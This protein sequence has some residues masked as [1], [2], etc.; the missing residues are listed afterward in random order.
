MHGVTL[1]LSQKITKKDK[2]LGLLKSSVLFEHRLMNF[3]IWCDVN[4][5]IY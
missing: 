3:K 5:K 4:E 2:A 1:M